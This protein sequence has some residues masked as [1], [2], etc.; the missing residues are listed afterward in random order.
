M[1][2]L[3]CLRSGSYGRWPAGGTRKRNAPCRSSRFPPGHRG[4]GRHDPAVGE[5]S[6]PSPTIRGLCPRNPRIGRLPVA[7]TRRRCL[8]AG[9]GGLRSGASRRPRVRPMPGTARRSHVPGRRRRP[10]MTRPAPR[11]LSFPLRKPLS[12]AGDSAHVGMPAGT[13]NGSASRVPGCCLAVAL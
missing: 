7:P 12:K 1:I 10:G 8:R 11:L 6:A 3:R 13:A 4:P 2:N 5:R 9:A